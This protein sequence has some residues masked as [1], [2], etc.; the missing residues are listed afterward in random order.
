MQ[1]ATSTGDLPKVCIAFPKKFE[2]INPMCEVLQIFCNAIDKICYG[3]S[4]LRFH[5]SA[6]ACFKHWFY[7][8][9]FLDV[10]AK[11]RRLNRYRE[12]PFTHILWLRGYGMQ[13]KA[14][15]LRST[16]VSPRETVF[17]FEG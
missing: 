3:T 2:P 1:R 4:P 5:G 17:S 9:P 14:G 6:K 11:R 10:P 15:S 7:S 8:H 16:A 13:R 12:N